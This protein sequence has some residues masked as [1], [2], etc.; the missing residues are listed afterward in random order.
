MKRIL[1]TQISIV[2]LL[3]ALNGYA[4]ESGTLIVNATDFENSEGAAMINLFREQDDIPKKPFITL[5]AKIT[6]GQAEFVIE[7][8]AVGSYAAIVWHD[9]NNNGILDHNLLPS[10]PLGCSNNWQ[11]GLFSGMPTFKKLKFI[12]SSA[13]NKIEIKVK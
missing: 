2:A 5:K 8:L 9:E 10:E 1:K 12:F 11:M 13:D 6:N 7:N 4:Q 3:I